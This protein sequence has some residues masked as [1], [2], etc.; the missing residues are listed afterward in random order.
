VSL[1]INSGGD[2][3]RVRESVEKQT[4]LFLC[5]GGT[6]LPGAEFILSCFWSARKG[7]KSAGCVVALSPAGPDR[8]RLFMAVRERYRFLSVCGDEIG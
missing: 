7:G 1:A 8:L 3:A 6:A 4:G 5:S 2:K